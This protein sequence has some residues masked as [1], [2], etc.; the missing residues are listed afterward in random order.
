[1][2][3]YCDVVCCG[4]LINRYCDMFCRESPRTSMVI[5]RAYL[6]SIIA[7]CPAEFSTDN[8]NIFTTARQRFRLRTVVYASPVSASRPGTSSLRRFTPVAT[9]RAAVDLAAI[10]QFDNSIRVLHANTHHL[11]RRQDLNAETSSLSHSPPS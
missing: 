8:I 3:L 9:N 6:E 5:L 11:L 7:A 2:H 4:N 10:H 1:M